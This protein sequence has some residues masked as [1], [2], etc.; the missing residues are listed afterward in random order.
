MEVLCREQEYGRLDS[1]RLGLSLYP[2]RPATHE[3]GRTWLDHIVA[4][5]P[6]FR[7]PECAVQ[8]EALT[9]GIGALDGPT[10]VLGV[11]AV[12]RKWDLSKRRCLYSLRVSK[13]FFLVGGIVRG[14]E[15]VLA[16]PA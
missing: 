9:L 11:Q 5:A 10:K 3:G 13:L 4:V 7:P 14:R 8:S 1:S 2:W 12:L 16:K 15:A 6:A